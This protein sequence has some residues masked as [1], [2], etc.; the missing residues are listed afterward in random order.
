MFLLSTKTVVTSYQ[1]EYTRYMLLLHKIVSF[2]NMV[3]RVGYKHNAETHYMQ[4]F[5]AETT[6]S[7][8]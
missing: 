2:S 1:I 3:S 7:S 8:K 4:L 6:I 5:V